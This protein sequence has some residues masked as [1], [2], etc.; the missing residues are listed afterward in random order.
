[1]LLRHRLRLDRTTLGGRAAQLAALSPQAVLERG[2]AI[3]T[4]RGDGAVVRSPD[5]VRPGERLAIRVAAGSF[6]AVAGR[7]E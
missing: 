3:V 6:P 1:V 4:R 5:E 2:Y 7:P